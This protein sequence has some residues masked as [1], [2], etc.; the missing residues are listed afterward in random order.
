MTG[1]QVKTH[2]RDTASVM[3]G[4]SKGK[5]KTKLKKGAL[6]M[7]QF[8]R[9]SNEKGGAPQGEIHSLSTEEMQ[10][11]GLARDVFNRRYLLARLQG[12]KLLSSYLEAENGT[13]AKS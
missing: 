11:I 8:E 7:K 2:L 9:P 12:L 3:M 1:S 6:R 4:V 10:F 5:V 13:T